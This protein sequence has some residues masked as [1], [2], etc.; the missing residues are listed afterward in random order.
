MNNTSIH[1]LSHK[2]TL[3]EL[4]NIQA[5][6]YK[7]NSSNICTLGRTLVCLFD[8]LFFL[9]PSSYYVEPI[10]TL[11]D[12]QLLL[13]SM[14]LGVASSGSWAFPF[15]ILENVLLLVKWYNISRKTFALLEEGVASKKYSIPIQFPNPRPLYYVK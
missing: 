5:K 10:N 2:S 3:F 9:P 14:K 15:P 6:D 12:A 1:Y 11:L 4:Q 13:S 7:T 8:I